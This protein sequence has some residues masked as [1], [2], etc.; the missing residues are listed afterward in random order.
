[1]IGEGTFGEVQEL[2]EDGW[3]GSLGRPRL[4]G[5]KELEEDGGNHHRGS[6]SD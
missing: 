4:L 5:S 6:A 3:K 1:M 2:E